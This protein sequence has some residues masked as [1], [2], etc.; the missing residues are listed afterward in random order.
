[1]TVP[2]SSGLVFRMVDQ[3]LDV[4]TELCSVPLPS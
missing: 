4:S 2:A 3:L 1:M